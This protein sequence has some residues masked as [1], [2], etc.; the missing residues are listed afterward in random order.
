MDPIFYFRHSSS[1]RWFSRF[2]WFNSTLVPDQMNRRTT[3]WILIAMVGIYCLLISALGTVAFAYGYRPEAHQPDHV[4]PL[5]AASVDTSAVFSDI[6]SS[7]PMGDATPLGSLL[8]HR[9]FSVPYQGC[10]AQRSLGIRQYILWHSF[11]KRNRHGDGHSRHRSDGRLVRAR[12]YAQQQ[13]TPI[14]SFEKNAARGRPRSQS[15][16][17]YGCPMSRV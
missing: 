10:R 16:N 13:V 11:S 5:P 6:A 3:A 17:R 8:V 9:E 1:L 12:H 4:Y 7:S 2:K 14:S 15:L